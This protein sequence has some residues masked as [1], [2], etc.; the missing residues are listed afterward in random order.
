MTLQVLLF[1]PGSQRC[2]SRTDL[3][4]EL[5]VTST[6]SL[7]IRHREAKVLVDRVLEEGDLGDLL[8]LATLGTSRS[9]LGQQGDGG[10]VLGV[11][12]RRPVAVEG[13]EGGGCDGV[14]RGVYRGGG[15]LEGGVDWG[16]GRRARRE[17]ER[18][19][20]LEVPEV[21]QTGG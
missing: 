14:E 9:R 15:R 13:G 12:V 21:K 16:G 19:G 17:A 3:E 2:L 10:Q 6:T 1:L 5:H 11:W 18:G 4:I 8:W 20:S 7:T